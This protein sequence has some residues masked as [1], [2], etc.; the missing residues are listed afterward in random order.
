MAGPGSRSPARSPVTA[1]TGCWPRWP[2]PRLATYGRSARSR[3][4]ARDGSWPFTAADRSPGRDTAAP[5][6]PR[7]CP[8]GSA[9]AHRADPE[10]A[11]VDEG[12]APG[13][14]AGHGDR[15]RQAGGGGWP[16]VTGVA[17]RAAARHGVDV[18]RGHG[19]PVERAGGGRDDAQGVITIGLTVTH[20]DH[21][22]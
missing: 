5:P 14:R 16:G 17:G 8:A 6:G 2:P 9:A 13:R 10:V 3:T 21:R 15:R 18:P 19:D 22:G 7:P 20:R 11:A 1:T 4:T 12:E